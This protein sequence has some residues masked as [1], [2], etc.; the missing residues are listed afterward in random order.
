M[1]VEGI[2]DREAEKPAVATKGSIDG[3]PPT[4]GQPHDPDPTETREWLESLDGVVYL[5]GHERAE[6]L[7]GRL[8]RQAERT[9]VAVPFNANTPYVNTIPPDEQPDFPGDR[10]IERKIK[11]LI[12]W[13]AMAMVVQANETDKTI[14]GHIGTFASS[15]TLYEIGFNH[16]FKGPDAIGGADLVYF[17]GHASPGMYARAFLEGRLSGSQLQNFRRELAPAPAGEQAQAPGA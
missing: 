1:T 8:H 5:H 15:A 6:Y 7:L 11:S 13:N 12:R 14:G 4:N 16:F 3:A 2:K 10:E 17:Q 9:G